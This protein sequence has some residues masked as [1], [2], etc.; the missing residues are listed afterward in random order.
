[1]CVNHAS[2]YSSKQ[3]FLISFSS[4]YLL[5]SF[6]AFYLLSSFQLCQTQTHIAKK[7]ASTETHHLKF[8]SC[9]KTLLLVALLI[10]H[11]L[12]VSAES[13][14]TRVNYAMMDHAATGVN[15]SV[16][17]HRRVRIC[18]GSYRGPRKH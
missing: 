8:S 3:R 13:E 7:T 16:G 4:S 15:Q 9:T 2:N 18:H 1:M 10:L 5:C 14:R 11:I 17:L 6:F 12:H